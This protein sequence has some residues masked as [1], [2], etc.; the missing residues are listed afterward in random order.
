[1]RAT[2]A[3]M[4]VCLA[5]LPASAQ[6]PTYRDVMDRYRV[7]PNDGV[8][9]MLALAEAARREGIETAVGA[10]GTNGWAW[11]QLASAAMMHTD[12]GLYF[13]TRQQ[14]SLPFF[15]DAERLLVRGLDASPGHA[16]FVR[17][18]Y[19][20]IESVLKSAGDANSAKSF[21]SHYAEWL[22]KYPQRAKALEAYHKG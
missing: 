2:S 9:R 8:E 15:A 7:S 19:G 13:L 4:L 1:M 5:L 14:P 10:S 18:W 16:L 12:A 20:T 11:E 6:A 21:A 17:R 3:A 22:K